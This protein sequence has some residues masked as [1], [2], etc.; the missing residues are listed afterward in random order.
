MNTEEVKPK[1]IKKEPQKKVKKEINKENYEDN[2]KIKELE[3]SL[4][5]ITGKFSE[6]TE[7]I[8]ELQ[9]GLMR[10][11]AEL[12]NYRKRKDEEVMKML[13]YSNEGIVKELIPNIDSFERAI[14][15]KTE[16]EA[17]LKYQEGFKMIYASLV[18]VLNKYDVKAIDGAN[19]PFDPTYHQAVLTE[20]KDGVEPG[21]VLEVLQK[22]YLLKDKVIRPAMVKVSE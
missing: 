9:D 6:A 17:I 20:H 13:Q 19:K 3:D 8:K 16:D 15:T 11:Q 22:G 18:N 21:M 1:V 10:S 2:K 12:I 4:N 5:E 14:M 7:H